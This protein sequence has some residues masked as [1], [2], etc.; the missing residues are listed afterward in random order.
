MN[1]F[2]AVCRAIICFEKYTDD[3]KKKKKVIIQSYSSAIQVM[4]FEFSSFGEAYS[5]KLFVCLDFLQ[6]A[7]LFK[8]VILRQRVGAQVYTWMGWL[9]LQQVQKQNV[10]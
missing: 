1:H 3:K 9:E 6:D 8:T 2:Q 5:F 10:W 4:S 7:S